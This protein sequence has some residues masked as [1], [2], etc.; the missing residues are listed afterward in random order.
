MWFK[1]RTFWGAVLLFVPQI[2]EAA[3]VV[4]PPMISGLIQ[5]IGGIVGAVGI[6][7]AIL[8]AGDKSE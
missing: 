7:G 6:R 2:V 5:A 3:G 4:I 1:S 8:R